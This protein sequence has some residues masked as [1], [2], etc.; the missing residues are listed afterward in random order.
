MVPQSFNLKLRRH[1]SLDCRS[2]NEADHCAP[3]FGVRVLEPHPYPPTSMLDV[4]K[5]VE[6]HRIRISV[7]S[8]GA[9]TTGI[10]F[11]EPK[12]ASKST[13]S[14]MFRL[15]ILRVKMSA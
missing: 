6:Y 9:P 5:Y 10:G 14:K 12:K 13:Y 4:G 7:G 8:I 15:H 1:L 11:F 2:A 3:A